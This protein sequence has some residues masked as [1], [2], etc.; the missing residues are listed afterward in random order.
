[1]LAGASSSGTLPILKRV[2]IDS[3]T[4]ERP[5]HTVDFL[6]FDPDLSIYGYWSDGDDANPARQV[7]PP[8]NDITKITTTIIIAAITNA[9]IPSCEGCS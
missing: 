4:P 3:A 2:S 5:D 9:Q 7:D 8:K 6:K 1:M